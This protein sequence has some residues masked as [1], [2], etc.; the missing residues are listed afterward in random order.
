MLFAYPVLDWASYG[1]NAYFDGGLL[2]RDEAAGHN[3]T[4][5]YAGGNP[6][7]RGSNHLALCP[8]ELIQQLDAESL[9]YKSDVVGADLVQFARLREMKELCSLLNLPE[10][11]VP[12]IVFLPREGDMHCGVL[13]IPPHWYLNPQTLGA[14]DVVLRKWLGSD[15]VQQLGARE[16]SWA[17]LSEMLPPLLVVLAEE[18]EAAVARSTGLGLLDPNHGLAETGAAAPIPAAHAPCVF[19]RDGAVWRITFFGTELPPI[20]VRYLGFDCIQYL[21]M[22]KHRPVPI[23]DL[24][25]MIDKIDANR[26]LKPGK[27]LNAILEPDGLEVAE[28]VDKMPNIDDKALSQLNQ[29]RR[30]LLKMARCAD[31]D[32][33]HQERDRLHE[34]RNQIERFLRDNLTI[35][36]R[37]REDS[38]T[39]NRQRNRVA[40]LCKRA[41]KTVEKASP[42][43]ARHLKAHVRIATDCFY[44][45]DRDINWRAE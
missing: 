23:R 25:Q 28:F 37:I 27:D 9:Y 19:E 18:I 4:I 40:K 5:I 7:K 24:I 41:F 6:A 30:D 31:Q 20:P 38:A 14:F 43:L 39:L 13:R 26:A 15:A 32:G 1:L 34:E 16:A 35:H 36:G 42:E 22:R 11:D 8:P 12:G 29:R 17:Y 10:R 45:P 3:V 33:N 44:S 2:D 21:L